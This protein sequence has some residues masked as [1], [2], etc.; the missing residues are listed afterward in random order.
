MSSGIF[1]FTLTA[2]LNNF[3]VSLFAT[4]SPLPGVIVSAA[5]PKPS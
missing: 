2:S 5:T 3:T 1:G 4:P